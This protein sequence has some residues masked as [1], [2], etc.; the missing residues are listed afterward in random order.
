MPDVLQD[1]LMSKIHNV[2]TQTQYQIPVGGF[3]LHGAQTLQSHKVANYLNI[4]ELEIVDSKRYFH[5]LKYQN[6]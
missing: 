5:Q 3:P 1:H 6:K 4:G 2:C